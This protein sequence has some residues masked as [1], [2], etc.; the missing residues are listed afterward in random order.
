MSKK[1]LTLQFLVI[2][3]LLAMAAPALADG[4]VQ[5]TLTANKSELTVGDPVQLTLAVTHPADGGVQVT[6]TAGDSSGRLPG[7]H[8]QVGA[9]VGCF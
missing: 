5:V 3:L 7:H 1:G 8:P 9:N 4:G 6:L 2:V